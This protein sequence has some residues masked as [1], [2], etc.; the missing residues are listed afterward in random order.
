MSK[1]YLFAVQ[2]ESGHEVVS[3]TLEV[4][5]VTEVTARRNDE[6]A[7][8]ELVKGKEVV[9]VSDDTATADEVLTLHRWPADDKLAEPVSK[10]L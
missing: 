4:A 10:A 8:V 1:S 9:A 7:K 5:K 6:T 2:R 3:A